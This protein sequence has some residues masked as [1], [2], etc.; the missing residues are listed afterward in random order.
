MD[1]QNRAGAPCRQL[2]ALQRVP[3]CAAEPFLG[4]LEFFGGVARAGAEF[5]GAEGCTAALSI[6]GLL[7]LS[8]YVDICTFLGAEWRAQDSATRTAGGAKAFGVPPCPTLRLS[9]LL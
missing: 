2:P 4:V 7:H 6:P 8:L 1:R 5:R 9:S 3:S